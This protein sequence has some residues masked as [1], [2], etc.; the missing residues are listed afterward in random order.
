MMRQ[1]PGIMSPNLH[2]I[3][4]TLRFGPTSIVGPPLQIGKRESSYRHEICL[5]EICLRGAVE[6]V[7]KDNRSCRKLQS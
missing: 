4:I 5:R 1:R 2:V 3:E 6:E 7:A